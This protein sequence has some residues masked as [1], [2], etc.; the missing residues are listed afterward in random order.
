M[1]VYIYISMYMYVY[2]DRY[3]LIML[4]M[5]FFHLQATLGSH[6]LPITGVRLGPRWWIGPLPRLRKTCAGRRTMPLGFSPSLL[7][8]KPRWYVPS[9]SSTQRKWMNIAYL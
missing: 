9:G 4:T 8:R 2:I 5:I 6:G 3:S 7:L 1:Y